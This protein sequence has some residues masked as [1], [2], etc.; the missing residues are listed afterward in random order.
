MVI[1]KYMTVF[2]GINDFGQLMNDFIVY[3][4]ETDEWLNLKFA[5]PSKI[6]PLANVAGYPVFYSER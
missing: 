4:L 5:N 2:G 1:N 6:P 3:D